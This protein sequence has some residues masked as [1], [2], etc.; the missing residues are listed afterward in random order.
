MTR[1]KILGSVR[2][3]RRFNVINTVRINTVKIHPIESTVNQ[4][5]GSQ[6]RTKTPGKDE[7]SSRFE[8]DAVDKSWIKARKL[9]EYSP[10]IRNARTMRGT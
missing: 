9:N 6:R 1:C 7:I 3:P 10:R 2:R 8:Q 5:F 4:N